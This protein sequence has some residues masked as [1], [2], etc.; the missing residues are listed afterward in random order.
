MGINPASLINSY[1]GAGNSTLSEETRRRLIALGID[2]STVNSEAQAQI[3]IQNVLRA[4]KM[5]AENISAKP[6]SIQQNCCAGE[7]ELMKKARELAQKMGLQL[8]NNLT[9]DEILK[10][11]AAQ[12][13]NVLNS[14][15]TD[16]SKKDLYEEYN[17]D[18]AAIDKSYEVV[19]NNENAL[20][21]SMNM[22][23]NINKM[24]LGL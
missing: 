3:I 14:D 24:I 2:P 16:K 9:L 15:T 17:Q 10:A 1:F 8:A 6:E 21:L 19:K 13:S 7:I 20:I 4:K 23:A 18:L 12:I 5:E 22:N 11:I